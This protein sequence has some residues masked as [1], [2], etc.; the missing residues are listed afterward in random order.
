MIYQ[1]VCFAE[2][3]ISLPY[4]NVYYS[5][6]CIDNKF[7]KVAPEKFQQTKKF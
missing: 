2:E 5:T 6:R 1:N 7:Q 3:L 4:S